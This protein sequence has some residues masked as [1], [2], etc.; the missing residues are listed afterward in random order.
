MKFDLGKVL[1]IASMV[2]GLVLST[3]AKMKDKSGPE[4]RDVVVAQVK[5]LLPIVEGIAE[6]DLADERVYNQA[7]D[8]LIAA[9]KAVAVAR[10]KVSALVANIKL[11]RDIKTS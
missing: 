7:I 5:E 8:E 10:S 1:G 11:I 2:H 9:E 4:K 3:Q 6:M